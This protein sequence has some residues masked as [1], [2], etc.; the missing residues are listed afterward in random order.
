MGM[1]EEEEVKPLPSTLLHPIP[2]HY[3]RQSQG[4]IHCSQHQIHWRPG[5]S[6]GGHL[7]QDVGEVLK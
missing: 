6:Q 1:E 4:S 7:G 3:H 2:P 5:C